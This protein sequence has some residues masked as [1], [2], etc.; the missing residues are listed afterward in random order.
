[1][2]A[3][4]RIVEKYREAVPEKEAKFLNYA[5]LLPFALPKAEQSHITEAY[6]SVPPALFITD[7]RNDI[8][9]LGFMTAPRAKSPDGEFA[10]DV[11]R[12]G[13]WTGECASRI[14]R[15]AGKVRIFTDRGWLT[16]HGTHFF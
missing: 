15:R 1:M 4:G 3:T 9:T 2:S 5:E 12:N 11:L 8:W 14:E 10:F 13:K 6:V 16:W 7:E